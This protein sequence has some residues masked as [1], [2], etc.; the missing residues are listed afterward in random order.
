M[1]P[2]KR[3]FLLS[4][5]LGVAIMLAVACGGGDKNEGTTSTSGTAAPGAAERTVAPA[6][7][8]TAAPKEQQV[9]RVAWTQPEF[10]DPHKSNFAQDIAVERLLS[11]PLFWVDEKGS[12]TAAVARE[13]PT[14]QNNGVSADGK[15]LTIKLKDNQKF[16]DGSPLTAK[17]FEYSI[18]RALHPKLASLYASELYNIVGA[19]Q[20][21]TAKDA[22]A[23]QIKT[24]WDGVGVRAI[25]NG[26]LEVRL[27]QPQPTITQILGMWMAYPVKQAAVEQ[28]GAPIENTDWAFNPARNI[29]NGPFVL[30][31]YREKDR[32]VVEANPNYTLEPKPKLNRIEMR[33]SEDE[34]VS[35]Q[36][37]RTGELD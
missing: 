11:R 15:T 8:Y 30:K 16:S 34:E 18:K 2:T 32:I 19:E 1:K 24:L 28:G 35:F 4:L 22:N 17:D 26:T 6:G 37:F 10:L 25:D 9:F 33:I 23:D 29:S 7:Q 5:S 13:L 12:P 31:E 36:A 14:R 27:N 20:L 21:N 3:G